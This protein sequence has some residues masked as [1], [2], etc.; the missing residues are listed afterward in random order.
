MNWDKRK[1]EESNRVLAKTE[2]KAAVKKACKSGLFYEDI[3][4]IVADA[5]NEAAKETN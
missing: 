5:V 1:I 3:C 4:S 2:L